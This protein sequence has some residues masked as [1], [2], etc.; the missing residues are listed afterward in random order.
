MGLACSTHGY[1]NEYKVLMDKAE[2]KR[3]FGLSRHKWRL[4]D[5]KKV[6]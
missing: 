1:G 5:L 3:P 2:G 4:M 6:T